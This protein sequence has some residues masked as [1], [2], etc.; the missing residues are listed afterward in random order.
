M[1]TAGVGGAAV[2]AGEAAA[3]EAATGE[4]AAAGSGGGSRKREWIEVSFRS[5]L[6]VSSVEVYETFGAGQCTS[7]ALW[8]GSSWDVVWQGD[9][10]RSLPREARVF[11]PQMQARTYATRHARI[12]FSMGTISQVD[13]VRAIGMKAPPDVAATLSSPK[14]RAEAVVPDKAK[15]AAERNAVAKP[16]SANTLPGAVP[17]LPGPRFRQAEAEISSLREGHRQEMD[18]LREY[19]EQLRA[20]GERMRAELDA[21]TAELV[22]IKR[23][24]SMGAAAS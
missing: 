17:G 12:E 16:S 18:Q 20:Y 9:A 3:G 15:V 10:H 6:Y 11:S 5:A 22:A 7:I 19:I 24:F 8:D 23:E 14:Q 21:R 4:A 2:A 1:P 13:A